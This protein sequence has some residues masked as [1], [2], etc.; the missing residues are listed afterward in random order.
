VLGPYLGNISGGEA[1]DLSLGETSPGLVNISEL[2]FLFDFELDDLQPSD[3]TLASLTF[4]TLA[5]GTSPLGLSINALGDA[6]GDALSAEIQKGSVSAV[7]EPAT[8]LLL[9]TG[10][11]G[12]GFLRGRFLKK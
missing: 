4:D 3:F 9:S 12:L 7:P 6:W 11:V 1:W 8:I 10:L 2:S 5:L